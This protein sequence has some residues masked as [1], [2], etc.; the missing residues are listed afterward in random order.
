MVFIRKCSSF[1]LH[2]NC[3]I[4]FKYRV[5]HIL[6]M[7]IL[8]ILKNDEIHDFQSNFHVK[9]K[10]DCSTQKSPFFSILIMIGQNHNFFRFK[11]NYVCWMVSRTTFLNLVASAKFWR[12]QFPIFGIKYFSI[13][14]KGKWYFSRKT[15][16]LQFSRYAFK[17]I[18]EVILY[19]LVSS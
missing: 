4:Y 18:F 19:F 7:Q 17:L 14:L 5:F 13:F 15:S 1:V 8:A 6:K 2:T 11:C 9:S 12:V 3:F 10:L 16:Y